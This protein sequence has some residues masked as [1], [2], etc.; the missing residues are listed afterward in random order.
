MN[1]YKNKYYVNNRNDYS[2]DKDYKNLYYKYK[3]KY[4]DLKAGAAVST[5]EDKFTRGSFLDKVLTINNDEYIENYDSVYADKDNRYFD[6]DTCINLI[7]AIFNKLTKTPDKSDVKLDSNNISGIN[8]IINIITDS[9]SINPNLINTKLNNLLNFYKRLFRFIKYEDFYKGMVPIFLK[10]EIFILDKKKVSFF[11]D[12]LDKSNCWLVFLFI[13]YLFEN[14]KLTVLEIMKN[15]CK[16]IKS[17]NV[18]IPNTMDD[19]D[20]N[21]NYEIKD[22]TIIFLDDC[23]YTGRQMKKNIEMFRDH[24]Y[25]IICFLPYYT[26]VADLNLQNISE[27]T[28][29]YNLLNDVNINSIYLL[30]QLPSISDNFDGYNTNEFVLKDKNNNFLFGSELLGI[31]YVTKQQSIFIFEHKVADYVSVLRPFLMG[32]VDISR[33]RPYIYSESEDFVLYTIKEEC[34]ESI[35]NFNF[36]SFNDISDMLNTENEV[37]TLKKINIKHDFNNLLNC[38]FEINDNEDMCY[39]TFYK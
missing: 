29:H 17:M 19:L 14:N 20:K 2:I 37:I 35:P 16:F 13:I 12:E 3:K 31:N 21:N 26:S 38:E 6:F 30:E 39:P 7:S 18:S 36:S 23:S 10:L 11:I 8:R 28:I 34:V 4:L 1:S 27:L 15:N 32:T 5:V 25:D 24:N 33:S 22:H 9:D